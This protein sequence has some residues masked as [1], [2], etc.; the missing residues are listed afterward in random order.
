MCYDDDRCV[1]Y[2]DAY[3]SNTKITIFK[4]TPVYKGISHFYN[5]YM[6][7]LLSKVKNGW[8]IFL[9][10]DDKL[11]HDMVLDRI[12]HSI[13]NEDDII[14]WKVKLGK[15]II[16]PKNIEKNLEMVVGVGFTFNSTH[17]NLS[18]WESIRGGDG[19]FIA[20]LLKNVNFNRK[21][22]DSILTATQHDKT[23]MK[24][25]KEQTH[26]FD[27]FIKSKN[28]QQIYISKLLAHFK[29]RVLKKFNLKEYDDWKQ[30]CIF[31]G[32]YSTSDII[33]IHD[34]NSRSYIMPGGSDVL[35]I[36]KLIKI[37]KNQQNN[38]FISISKDIQ[39]RLSDMNIDSIHIDFNLVDY[40]LFRP[41]VKKRN[42]IFIYDGIHKNQQN[43]INIY[44]KKYYDKV[45]R[46]LPQ[47]EYILSSDL[48]TFI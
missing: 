32:V 24:G 17:K 18:Q 1:D 29:P 3:T 42:K 4:V 8:I 41:I 40:N 14:F 47:Y 37:I 33:K 6:N 38:E 44:G 21:F 46:L 39:S 48:K 31:F 19:K 35:N 26:E 2:L 5:L 30:P 45:M 28:I 15:Q 20:K 27:K 16:F 23:G 22:I 36:N 10:D 9:D 43:A 7:E 34:H 25:I 12:R 13:H 11:S